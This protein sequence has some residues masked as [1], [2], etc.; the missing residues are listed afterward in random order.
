MLRAESLSKAYGQGPARRRVLDGVDLT[1]A[2]GDF[3]AVTGPSGSGKSTLLHCLSGLAAPDTGRVLLDGVD[4]AGLG[5]DARTDLRAA[6]MG[7]VFQTLNLL[8]ALTVRENVELPL[9]LRDVPRAEAEER[10]ARAL[11]D[12][13]L[14]DRGADLPAALSGGEQQRVALARAV[15]AD[16]DLLWADEPTGALDAASG[17]SLLQLLRRQAGRRTVVVVTHDPQVSAVAD[18][19]V[20]MRDGRLEG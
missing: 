1:I 12:V 19:V 15:V 6:R 20:R 17:Q 11:D 14:A 13:G 9:V 4:L 10:V 2:D 18:R 5:D 7:F 3:L 8:P 16:P